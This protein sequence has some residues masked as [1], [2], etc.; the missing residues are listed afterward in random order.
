MTSREHGCD[1]L[2][3]GG[4]PAGIAARGGAGTVLIE[5]AGCLG[6]MGTAGMVPALAPFHYN[7]RILSGCSCSGWTKPSLRHI[8]RSCVQALPPQ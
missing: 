7:D 5:S 8:H 2:V 4:G 6:G 3:V 1:V